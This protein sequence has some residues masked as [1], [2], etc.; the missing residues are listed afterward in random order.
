MTKTPPNPMIAL[1]KRLKAVGINRSY[2][3]T[4]VLPEWWDDD[5]ARNPSGLSEAILYLVNRLGL[6]VESLQGSGGGELQFAVVEAKFK[7]RSDTKK[8]DLRL[9]KMIAFRAAVVAARGCKAVPISLSS[10]PMAIRQAILN[11][12]AQ[13]VTLE[14][15]LNYCWK[16]GIPVIHVAEF[17]SLA[18]KMDGLSARVD[19]RSVIVLSLNAASKSRMAFILAHELGHLALGHLPKDVDVLL[20]QSWRQNENDL[21]EQAANTFAARLLTG[22]HDPKFTSNSYLTGEQLAVESARFGKKHGIAPGVVA[23]NYGWTRKFFP[24]ALKAL[25][26]LEPE[27]HAAEV[28]TNCALEYIDE[29]SIP[30]EAYEWLL[31][32]MG[33]P[34]QILV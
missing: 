9:A 17:P 11:S 34:A 18:K 33:A 12:G 7:K 15:L 24:V 6:T 10:D 22:M 1:R 4:R 2:L 29:E 8:D 19:G 31:R 23:L 25:S 20:D 3:D 14:S 30:T 21:E 32:L 27:E 5:A 16:Q 13:C 28:V 26:I